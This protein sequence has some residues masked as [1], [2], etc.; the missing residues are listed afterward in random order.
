MPVAL[1]SSPSPFYLCRPQLRAVANTTTHG[2]GRVNPDTAGKGAAAHAQTNRPQRV[3]PAGEV[4]PKLS[5]E[6]AQKNEVIA[7]DHT[8]TVTQQVS[9]QKLDTRNEQLL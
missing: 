9:V 2:A 5:R 7:L 4:N 1:I 3:W 6:Q 8:D